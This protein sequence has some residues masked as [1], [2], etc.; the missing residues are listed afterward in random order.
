MRKKNTKIKAGTQ[1]R[2]SCNIDWKKYEKFVRQ[3]ARIR[4]ESINWKSVD[5]EINFMMGAH[6]VMFYC[7]EQDKLPS[8]MV[9][10]YMRGGNT[11][12]VGLEKQYKFYS[13]EEDD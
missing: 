6:A 13:E 8:D 4:G 1:K 7:N 3:H 12:L 11:S 2:G 5:D 10:G 9:F